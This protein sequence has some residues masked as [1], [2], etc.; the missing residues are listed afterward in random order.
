MGTELQLH[1]GV[2]MYGHIVRICVC[3]H[4]TY[5]QSNSEHAVV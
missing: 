1:T 5:V 3:M 2:G 4:C